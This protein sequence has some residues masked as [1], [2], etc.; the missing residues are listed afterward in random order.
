MNMTL[1]MKNGCARFFRIEDLD[2]RANLC[3]KNYPAS[4]KNDNGAVVM[5]K[6]MCD[7][8][9]TNNSINF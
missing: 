8:N 5:R 1:N 7:T 3:E 9:G 6:K 2:T 4:I